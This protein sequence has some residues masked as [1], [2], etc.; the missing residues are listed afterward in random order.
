MRSPRPNQ[1]FSGRQMIM[2]IA[3]ETAE[4]TCALGNTELW[5]P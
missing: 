3:A 5:I 4:D 1:G 2:P